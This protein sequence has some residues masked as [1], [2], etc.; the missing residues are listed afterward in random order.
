MSEW[1]HDFRTSYLKLGENARKYCKVHQ[2]LGHVPLIGLTGT[3]SFD[4]L[5]DVKRELFVEESEFSVIRPL[6]STRKELIFKIIQVPE[7]GY[8]DRP[9]KWKINEAV[10]KIKKKYLIEIINNLSNERWGNRTKV[11]ANESFISNNY[12]FPNS[13]IIFCPHVNWVHGVKEIAETIKKNLP[14]L[15]DTTGIYAGQLEDIYGNQIDLEA[16]QDKFMNNE[17]NLLVATKAFGMGVDKPNIRFTI[18]YSMPQSIEAFYQEAGRAGRDKQKSYCYVVHSSTP[19]DSEVGEMLTVDKKMMLSF[20]RNS[21]PGIKKEKIIISELLD[22]VDAT[23]VTLENIYDTDGLNLEIPIIP[24]L[25]KNGSHFRIYANTEDGGSIGYVTVDPPSF[26]VQI[27]PNGSSIDLNKANSVLQTYFNHLVKKCPFGVSLKNWISEPRNQPGI[28]K[29]LKDLKHNE[30]S[31]LL[32][33]FEN[34]A[35]DNVSEQLRI[36]NYWKSP[37]DIVKACEYC[38]NPEDFLEKL[39][40]GYQPNNQDGLQLNQNLKNYLVKQFYRIRNQQETFRAIYRLSVIGVID[41]YDIDY[42]RKV[43]SLLITKRQ[44]DYYVNK[45]IS[46]I[47]RF[48]SPENVEKAKRNI[49]TQKGNT[50]IQKCCGYLTDFVYRKIAAKR[51]EAIDTME[52]AITSKDFTERVN[53]YFDSKYIPFLRDKLYEDSTEWVWDFLGKEA[54]SQDNISHILG[55]C[56][57]L[58]DEN[59]DNLSYRIL[60]VFARFSHTSSDIK[61]S[62]VEDIHKLRELMNS[63]GF[64]ALD[65]MRLLSRIYN[66]V[67]KFDKRSA[68]I[69]EPEFLDYH[70]GWLKDFNNTIKVEET[71]GRYFEN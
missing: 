24:N 21:F 15:S 62:G 4:V 55:A 65:F 2:K 43:V 38:F 13:G 39:F 63:K 70:L 41:E 40:P 52:D 33:P 56:D 46:Y 69:L 59:P 48:D 18:H 47:S 23:K 14:E 54:N 19:I 57:R 49:L 51:R 30:T 5:E 45:L 35:P 6:E 20:H 10:S 27:K 67:S 25:W 66:Q 36:A 11:P 16:T 28:E 71:D 29:L 34:M 68:R 3:A 44:D 17:L 64:L 9:D 37:K 1:G 22:Q 60:R 32:V 61:E 8:I 7:I 12:D 50:V 53:T 42:N 26:T 58:L 31:T